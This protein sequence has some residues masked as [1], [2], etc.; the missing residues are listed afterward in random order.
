MGLF[1]KLIGQQKEVDAAS[2]LQSQRLDVLH[3][4]YRC[5]GGEIDLICL[6]QT[7]PQET[8]LVF[9]EVKHRQSTTFGEPEEAI[10]AAKQ[11]KLILCAQTFL[12]KH[13]DYQHHAMRFDS[14]SFTGDQSAPNWIQ[15]AFWLE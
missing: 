13:P 5:K 1:S 11:R 6:E 10:N 3:K 15:N 8:T 14:L 7:S 12:Q 9:V 4:N 2:F